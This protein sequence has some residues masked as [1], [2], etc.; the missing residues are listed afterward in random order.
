MEDCYIIAQGN[1]LLPY[2]YNKDYQNLLQK[3]NISKLYSFSIADLVNNNISTYINDHGNLVKRIYPHSKWCRYNKQCK[4]Y[5]KYKDYIHLQNN[6]YYEFN[7]KLIQFT[8]ILENNNIKKL[9]YIIGHEKTQES[10]YTSLNYINQN[11]INLS[12]F[13][14]TYHVIADHLDWFIENKNLNINYSNKKQIQK[15]QNEL[16][17]NINYF[18]DKVCSNLKEEWWLMRGWSKEYAKQKISEIQIQRSNKCSFKKKLNPEKYKDIQPN[19][20]RYWL[21]YGYSEEESKQKVKERQQTFT[22]EKCIRKYGEIDGRKKFEERQ[23]KWQNTLQSKDDYIEVVIKR[24]SHSFY[25]NIS[26]ELFENLYHKLLENNIKCN[27]YF[28]NLNHEWGFGI[29]KHG[30]V[31]YDFVIPELKYAI[32]FNGNRFHPNKEKLSK[33]EFKN[34]TNPWGKTAKD[35]YKQDTF[36]NNAII[37]KGFTLDIIWEDDYLENKNEILNK[38][39]NKIKQ[40]YNDTKIS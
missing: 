10:L 23:K 7:N 19:Q 17:N 22:L 40:I 29:K 5:L 14:K 36:K 6:Y 8:N 13:I 27:V 11:I 24:C 28:H 20:V 1:H 39:L 16:L 25:S 38:I 30:G 3:Y 21:K 34:W 12:D 9:T 31:L 33:E 26:Q 35:I 4:Q 15:I 32:E 18:S 37:K 2:V